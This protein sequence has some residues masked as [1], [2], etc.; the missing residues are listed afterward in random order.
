MRTRRQ[1]GFS[2]MELAVAMMIIGVL[3][4]LGFKGYQKFVV[5]ANH[6]LAYDRLDKVSKALDL[7]YIRNGKYPELSNWEAMITPGSPLVK[8]DFLPPNMPAKDPWDQPY[9]GTSGKGEYKVRC[10]GDPANQEKFGLIEITPGQMQ[11]KD[12]VTTQTKPAE[13]APK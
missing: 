6:R 1:R 8:E 5:Q 9:E 11:G 3:A 7:Y 2:L 13:G 4:T 12:I 10:L